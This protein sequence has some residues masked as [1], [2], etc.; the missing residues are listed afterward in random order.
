MRSHFEEKS[1]EL[2]FNLELASGQAG[3]NVFAPGQ[4]IEGALGFDVA[5]QLGAANPAWA[6]IALTSRKGFPIPGSPAVNL[7]ASS[8]NLFVQYK[9]SEYLMGT[10]ARHRSHFGGAYRRFKFD[11][12]EDQLKTLQTL[13]TTVGTAAHVIY[14]A[15]KFHT[16]TDLIRTFAASTVIAES[17]IA[18]SGWLGKGHSAYNFK[19]GYSALLNPEPEEVPTLSA[20]DYFAG[21]D[22]I[23]DSATNFSTGLDFVHAAISS[24][25]DWAT[26]WETSRARLAVG[27]TNSGPQTELGS[28]YLE[29]LA[30]AWANSLTWVVLDPAPL[31]HASLG[32]AT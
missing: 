13:E 30:F 31:E 18:S 9:R 16:M 3:R 12:P 11:D 15:P 4:F 14:A 26:S 5:W 7:P 17:V 8:F 25:P 6:A 23:R 22:S 24:M 27:N 10:R 1:Y 29:V 21:F 19:P 32:R 2:G 20:V 28:K